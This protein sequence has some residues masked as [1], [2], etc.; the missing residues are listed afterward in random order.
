MKHL[1]GIYKIT[2]PTGKIYVGQSVFIQR[3]F[4]KYKRLECKSQRRL[5]NSFK[6]HTV[7]K[8]NF[9]I[10]ELCNVK[11]L[12]KKERYY[13]ELY[14]VIGKNGLNC[15]LTNC[16]I[17]HKIISTKTRLKLKKGRLGKKHTTESKLKMSII[18]KKLRQKKVKLLKGVYSIKIICTDTNIIYNSIKECAELNSINP[19]TLSRKLSGKRNNNT[20]FKYYEE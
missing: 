3:R 13:Q 18:Q 4:L 5:Y 2:S 11:S 16:N 10:I 12:N 14:N 8:H 7:E 1:V 19:S 17:S 15:V 20:T 9:E 6:R